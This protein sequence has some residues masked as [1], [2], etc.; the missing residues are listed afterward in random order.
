MSKIG[1][2]ILVCATLVLSACSANNGVDS[3]AART[4]AAE[5]TMNKM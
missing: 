1:S 2:M 4:V 3:G 5:P